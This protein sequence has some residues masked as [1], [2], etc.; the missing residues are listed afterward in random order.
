MEAGIE[1]N[2]ARRRAEDAILK[3]QGALVLAR[4]LDDTALFERV[5]QRLPEELL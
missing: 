3:I 1:P 2:C 4:G 5:L